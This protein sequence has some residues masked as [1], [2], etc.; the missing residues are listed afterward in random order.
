M[1]VKVLIT[2]YGVYIKDESQEVK[3]LNDMTVQ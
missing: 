1:C 2:K 3:G